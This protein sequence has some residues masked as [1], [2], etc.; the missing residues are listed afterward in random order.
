MG[1]S[2]NFVNFDRSLSLFRSRIPV[3]ITIPATRTWYLARKPTPS[4]RQLRI[5]ALSWCLLIQVKKK[6]NVREKKKINIVSSMVT[7]E[8]QKKPGITPSRTLETNAILGPY[9]RLANSNATHIESREKVTAVNL[10]E[11]AFIPK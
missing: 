5:N 11:A 6:N 1:T 3:I 7:L 10:P 8:T 4:A 9:V 2:R